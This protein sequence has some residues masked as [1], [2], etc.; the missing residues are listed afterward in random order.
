MEQQSDCRLPPR[1]NFFPRSIERKPSSAWSDLFSGRISPPDPLRRRVPIFAVAEAMGFTGSILHEP[2]SRDAPSLCSNL[3]VLL[4]DVLCP[5]RY[6]VFQVPPSGRALII[7][8]CGYLFLFLLHL[9]PPSVCERGDSRFLR[10]W[11]VVLRKTCS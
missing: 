10:L 7:C 2:F 5:F 6:F 4:Q 1:K 9:P 8:E 3:A 11:V